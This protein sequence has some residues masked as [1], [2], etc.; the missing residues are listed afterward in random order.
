[1]SARTATKARGAKGEARVRW[2]GG[3]HLVGTPL[4]CDALFARDACFVSHAHVG[5]AGRHR[6]VI[7]TEV[8]AKLLFGTAGPGEAPRRT[9]RASRVAQA[10]DRTTLAVP[11][12]RPFS[13][14]TSRL[15]LYPSGYFLGA[16]SLLVETKDG[17]RVA[18]AG[19]VNP[20][21]G[22]LGGQGELRA[23]DV[24]VVNATFG[25]ARFRFPPAKD[26]Q[27]AV[28]S[29][30]AHAHAEGKTP[31]L[32][33]STLG[34]GAELVSLLGSTYSLRVHRSLLELEGH[35]RELAYPRPQVRP[36]AGRV[37]DGDD[38]EVVVWPTQAYP[39]RALLK[40]R[41]ARVALVSGLAL[42]AAVPR[43]L[44]VDAAFPL[45]QE[46]DHDT[47]VSYVRETGAREVYLV[48]AGADEL[49]RELRSSR[50][51]AHTL[52]PPQQLTLL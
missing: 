39:A 8:T 34:G 7:A 25:Q 4:W 42:E 43:S 15:E 10:P 6:Q 11:L 12:G 40:I 19:S 21:G 49:A 23:C 44:G 32:L 13:L 29:F 47:L 17:V 51:V 27:V 48:G 37:G 3:V 9:A 5:H 30:V 31:V 24:L 2:Q 20:A 38:V 14:G 45:S 41:R 50:L 33:T 22:G 28:A 36:L 35:L 52:G 18:Y 16:S 1:M 26:T 46:A